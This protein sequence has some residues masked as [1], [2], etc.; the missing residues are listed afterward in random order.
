MPRAV[1]LF[2]SAGL[3]PVPCPADYQSHENDEVIFTDFLWEAGYLDRSTLAIRERIGY[4]WI[5]L[6]G[7]T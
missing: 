6:R 5:W 4:L 2:R 7:K 1:A 3:N